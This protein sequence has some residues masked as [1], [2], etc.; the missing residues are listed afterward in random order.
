MPWCQS[1]PVCGFA[2]AAGAPGR[3]SCPLFPDHCPAEAQWAPWAPRALMGPEPSHLVLCPA[4]RLPVGAAGPRRQPSPLPPCSVC[5]HPRTQTVE[6]LRTSSSSPAPSP[7]PACVTLCTG[8]GATAPPASCRLALGTWPRLSRCLAA[9]SGHFGPGV[10]RRARIRRPP[11]STSFAARLFGRNV[12]PTGLAS[13]P[14]RPRCLVASAVHSVC[15][16]AGLDGPQNWS[17]LA[18]ERARREAGSRGAQPLAAPQWPLTVPSVPRLKNPALPP[19]HAR[20]PLRAPSPRSSGL[21]I[22]LPAC[23]SVSLLPCRTASCPA[24]SKG[25]C[26]AALDEATHCNLQP[27]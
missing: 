20:T 10:T 21:S 18:G 14:S 11:S 23:L 16:S 5:V 3:Y 22:C 8:K 26:C 6:Q 19:A 12:R 2:A 27:F 17:H 7:S 25:R 15:E 9:A 13:R 4:A 1:R 24:R